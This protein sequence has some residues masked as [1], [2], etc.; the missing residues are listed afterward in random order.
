MSSEAE[1][2]IASATRIFQGD[3]FPAAE[4]INR[5]E[6]LWNLSEK[7]SSLLEADDADSVVLRD[8][9]ELFDK[10]ASMRFE[11]DL[12]G[13]RYEIAISL[14][15]VGW[16]QSYVHGNEPEAQAWLRISDSLIAQ[17]MTEV[18]RL[19]SFLYLDEGQKS[20][21][22]YSAFQS[23]SADVFLSLCIL[24]RDRMI[25]ARQVIL[26]ATGLHRWLAKQSLFASS[27]GA[28]FLTESAWL[29]AS[30]FRFL[31]TTREC[32]FWLAVARR[33]CR[34][35]RCQEAI[36][37][38]LQFVAAVEHRDL[39]RHRRLSE[40][41][42]TLTTRFQSLGM[43]REALTATFCLAVTRKMAGDVAVMDD[44]I[45]L[46]RETRYGMTQS[47]AAMAIANAAD[48]LTDEA[49]DSFVERCHRDAL[50]LAYES[51]D[52]TMI[53]SVLLVIADHQRRRNRASQ[54]IR[55]FER[56]ADLFELA[57]SVRMHAYCKIVLA[58][59]LVSENRT[60][61]ALSAL[62][63]AIPVVERESLY[64]EAVHAAKLLSAI[65]GR[66]APGNIETSDALSRLRAILG[67]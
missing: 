21:D 30:G 1:R 4:T 37:L 14:A 62:L 6:P 53:A 33:N 5:S 35:M 16:K 59:A 31:G 43:Y 15:T 10:L 38:K 51:S 45:T 67:R 17:P 29:C 34:R 63:I 41:F 3:G 8:A 26:A 58:E 48:M 60:D 42:A 25:K 28:F 13:E 7:A 2:I 54:A 50:T 65:P 47:I 56:A 36:R 52:V 55:L 12:F 18:D 46:F 61:E 11:P 20:D 64:P 44:L 57:G 9:G 66:F 49:D 40:R 24:R 23:S 39:H 32:R 19:E 22:L 27:I